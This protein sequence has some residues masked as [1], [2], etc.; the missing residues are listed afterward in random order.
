MVHN[1]GG[2]YVWNYEERITQK[3]KHKSEKIK[4]GEMCKISGR[5]GWFHH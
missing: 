3:K 5:D 1:A 2:V 4:K